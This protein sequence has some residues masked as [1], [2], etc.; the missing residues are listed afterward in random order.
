MPFDD[1]FDYEKSVQRAKA[2]KAREDRHDLGNE[3]AGLSTGRQI[4]FLPNGDH[5]DDRRQEQKRKDAFRS[6]LELLLLTDPFYAAAYEAALTTLS[7]AEEI[8]NTALIEARQALQ[9]AEE[10]LRSIEN[11]ASRLRNGV[12]VFRRADGA[13][14]DET[15]RVISNEEVAS[16]V[17][18]PGSPSYEAYLRAKTAMEESKVSLAELQLYQI[19]VLGKWRDRLEDKD[20][21]PSL[22][23][24]N[25]FQQQILEQAPQSIRPTLEASLEKAAPKDGA[26]SATHE[27]DYAYQEPAARSDQ[28]SL[29]KI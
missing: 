26:S 16:I 10:Q 2:K 12:R 21:P 5:A 28:I 13:I 9:D 6:A 25:E 1:E 22:E 20:N 19:D 29:P 11:R 23:E 18:K 17:W 4:R 14:V 15:G 3:Q 8:V 7:D 24:L 27:D